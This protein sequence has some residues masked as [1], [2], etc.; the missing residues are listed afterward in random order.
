MTIF[1]SMY[2]EPGNVTI[3][4]KTCSQCGS[5]AKICPAEV[6]IMDDGKLQVSDK[7]LFGCM[8]C[9]HCMMVCS[10][11]AISVRGRGVSPQDLLPLP[12]PG[13]RASADQLEALM[14]ARRSVRRFR[15]IPVDS[16]LVERVVEIASTAPMGVPPWDIGCV[17]VIGNEEVR[18]IADEIIKGYEGFLKI[19][20]PWLLAVMRPFIGKVKYEMFAGFVLPLAQVYV[21][22]HREGRDKLFYDA[23]VLLIFHHSPYTD[24]LDARIACTYAMLAAESLGL[25][26]TIIGGAPPILERNKP[27]CRQL[28]IPDSNKPSVALIL[29]HPA[30]SF[31]KTIRR[32][33]AHL[34]TI[35]AGQL[36]SS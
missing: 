17:S 9:G 16:R 26:S 2:R 28:G 1:H 36:K 29:G 18:R 27:L 25:G 34:S 15:E 21:N 33:F 19:F 30:V 4:E 32:R 12:G 7:S 6:L 35:D 14:R 13:E 23:P 3:D 10:T 24:V 11:G 31:R 22:A 5:C 8:A 20:K